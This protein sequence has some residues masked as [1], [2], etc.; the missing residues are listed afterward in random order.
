MLPCLLPLAAVALPPR[1]SLLA[2]P[3]SY[4]AGE[5]WGANSFS[6]TEVSHPKTVVF[7]GESTTAHLKNTGLLSHE[8]YRA[9]VLAPT[10]NTMMLSARVADQRLVDPA[11][12]ECTLREYLSRHA[13]DVLVLSFGLNGIV[14]FSKA[15]ERYLADYK[16]LC[17]AVWTASPS[18]KILLQ[19]IYPVARN[20]VDW[21][22]SQS[23]EEI[24]R[25]TR[26]LNRVLEEFAAEDER[27]TYVNTAAALTDATGYLPDADTTDGIHLTVAAYDKMLA[28]LRRQIVC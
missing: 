20:P 9:T 6:L 1:H 23:P 18:T 10:T 5:G 12:G 3:A 4:D 17:N 15:P 14:G 8:V 26:A 7:L 2:A 22:F 27:I 13:P 16:A 11:E 19:S 25:A 21:K 24:N 28:V